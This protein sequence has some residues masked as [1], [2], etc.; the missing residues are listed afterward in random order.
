MDKK[1]PSVFRAHSSASR[2]TI[3]LCSEIDSVLVNGLVI[4]SFTTGHGTLFEPFSCVPTPSAAQNRPTVPETQRFRA[5]LP[6]PPPRRRR[7]LHV[8]YYCYYVWNYDIYMAIII[9]ISVALSAHRPFCNYTYSD[10][11]Q[12]TP[13]HPVHTTRNG[14]G[15]EASDTV[16]CR[17][18]V[19]GNRVATRAY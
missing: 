18:V 17:R 3:I 7:T 15:R 11:P 8:Y 4:I 14:P 5:A 16:S 1:I 12:T 9:V 6:P 13:P 2:F 10:N 19:H